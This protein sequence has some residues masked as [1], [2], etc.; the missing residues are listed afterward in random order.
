MRELKNLNDELAAMQKDC[1]NRLRMVAQGESRFLEKQKQTIEYLSKFRAYIQETDSKRVRAEKRIEEER[2]LISEADL[3]IAKLTQRLQQ[4]KTSLQTQQQKLRQF[5]RYREYLERV[6]EHS[7]AQYTDVEHMLTRLQSLTTVHATLQAKIA[8][9]SQ[10]TSEMQQQRS[11]SKQD[12]ENTIIAQNHTLSQLLRQFSHATEHQMVNRAS[13]TSPTQQT[14]LLISRLQLST[15]NLHQ[16]CRAAYPVEITV[17][18]SHQMKLGPSVVATRELRPD[19]VRMVVGQMRGMLSEI[20]R[21]IMDAKELVGSL[22]AID[23]EERKKRHSGRG[24]GG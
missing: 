21:V 13:E 20:K 22:K 15:R 23:S 10:E 2:R 4:A 6:V 3:E 14:A 18:R 8:K 17:Q 7:D 5:R 24:E 12:L 9:V 16:R 11:K 19:Q 1:Q